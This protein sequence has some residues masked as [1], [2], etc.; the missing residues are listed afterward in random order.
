MYITASEMEPAAASDSGVGS[1][2]K[3]HR[4]RDNQAALAVRHRILWHQDPEWTKAMFC[5]EQCCS[6]RHCCLGGEV[7]LPHVT[8]VCKVLAIMQSWRLGSSASLGLQSRHFQATHCQPL[9]AAKELTCLGLHLQVISWPAALGG[10]L[11]SL[12]H[13]GKP[14]V[15]SFMEHRPLA[16]ILWDSSMRR[17]SLRF[18]VQKVCQTFHA[19]GLQQRLVRGLPLCDHCLP[20][21]PP[22]HLQRRLWMWARA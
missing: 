22:G 16:K 1:G 21:R 18:S 10:L 8:A 7:H 11:A 6:C 2:W 14:S 9:A 5:I 17:A 15:Y 19:I 20:S 4:A 13:C 12:Q 3:L